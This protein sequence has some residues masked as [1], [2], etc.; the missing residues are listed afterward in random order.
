[1]KKEYQFP[2]ILQ[3][4]FEV[5]LIYYTQHVLPYTNSLFSHLLTKLLEQYEETRNKKRNE[6]NEVLTHFRMLP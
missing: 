4:I 6:N 5:A 1:M 2:F 3:S